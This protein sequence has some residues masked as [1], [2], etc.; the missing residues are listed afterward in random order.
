MHLALDI[1][2][3]GFPLGVQGVE[4]QIQVM[5]SGL[6]GVDR[7]TKGLG[8]AIHAATSGACSF[9]PLLSRRPK[10]LGPFQFVPVMTRAIAVRLA[11]VFS[12]QT[13]PSG[14]I[15]TVWRTPSNSRTRTV[16]DFRRRWS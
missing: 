3:A 15:V 11:N 9:L 6:S 2:L 12:C 8:F 16:P 7:T 1:G 14:T 13:Y 10:N 4:F 5:L